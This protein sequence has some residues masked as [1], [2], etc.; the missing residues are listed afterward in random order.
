MNAPWMQTTGSPTP[1]S[2]YSSV[3]PSTTA[4]STRSAPL[5]PLRDGSSISPL[6]TLVEDCAGRSSHAHG[7]PRSKYGRPPLHNNGGLMVC[8]PCRSARTC[9]PPSRRLI[10]RS[11]ALPRW[12]FFRSRGSL[13]TVHWPPPSILNASLRPSLRWNASVNQSRV[14]ESTRSKASAPPSQ[15][16]RSPTSAIRRSATAFALPSSAA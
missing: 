16:G 11:T 5:L 15:T 6:E 7:R 8:R 3:M 12:L 9:G 13:V 1:E 10:R 14:R 2:S 4:R